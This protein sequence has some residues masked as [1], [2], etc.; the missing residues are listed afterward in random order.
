MAYVLMFR[1]RDRIWLASA[2]RRRLG[3]SGLDFHVHPGLPG[4]RAYG[5]VMRAAYL[6]YE[7]REQSSVTH[8]VTR[9]AESIA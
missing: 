6:P 4:R 5:F 2:F 1:E 7:S 8:G 3:E 9:G